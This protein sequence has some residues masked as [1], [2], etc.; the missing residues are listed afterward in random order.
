MRIE[1]IE[2]RINRL[3]DK[4]ENERAEESK[5]YSEGSR[6]SATI[7]LEEEGMWIKRTVSR[8]FVRENASAEASRKEE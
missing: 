8:E 6:F 3:F 7:E 4:I 2:K 5:G 1:D